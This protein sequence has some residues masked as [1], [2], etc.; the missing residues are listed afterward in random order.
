MDWWYGILDWLRGLFTREVPEP[1]PMPTVAGDLRPRVVLIIHNPII[2]SEGGRRLT[3][4]LGW[5]DPDDLVR[6][7]QADL[8]E[9]SGGQV[10]YQVVERVEVDGWVLKR[11]GFRYDEET[12][13][14]CW[15]NQSGFHKPDEA[16]YARLIADFDLVRKV[17]DDVVDEVWLFAYPYAGYY[18]SRMAG[19]GAFW[20]NS[21]PMSLGSGLSRHFVIMGFNYERAVGPMLESFGHRVES[22]MERVWD[23]WRGENNL[24]KRFTRY[25]LT[26]PGQANCGN[27]HFAPNSVRDYDWGNSRYVLSNCDDWLNFPDFQGVARRVNCAE[28]G[29]GDIREHHHWWLRHLPKA[30]GETRGILNNWWVYAVSPNTVG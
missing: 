18:E 8:R 30:P 10:D 17:E 4:V 26:A 9:A 23:R 7:Y 27:V 16:D 5:H 28:W 14:R 25:D 2:H 13:L 1:V 19:P 21:P 3:Q 24:W 6:Q 29:N 20:C 22:I 12:Y 11:D 15:R